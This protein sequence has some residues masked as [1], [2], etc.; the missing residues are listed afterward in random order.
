MDEPH[1]PN[2][3]F[4]ETVVPKSAA[5]E[6]AATGDILPLNIQGYEILNQLGGGAF[7]VVY[8]AKQLGTNRIV[9]IKHIR[10]EL[11]SSEK[12]RQ[13]FIREASIATQMKH[14]N[15]VECLGF[16]FAQDSPY[17]VMEYIET[18]DI[19]SIAMKHDPKRRLRLAVKIAVEVLDALQYAHSRGIV[20]RDVK[21]A[22]ILAQRR[23]QRLH[24]KVSDFGLAKLF[25][26]AG[27]SG[28]T[29]SDEVC[30]TLAY[31][32]PEQLSN[33]RGAGPECDVYSVV[34]CLFR[35]ITGQF[36]F[37][38]GTVAEIVHRKLN[39]NPKL[40]SKLNSEV[41]TDLAEIIDRGLS[42]FRERSF[43]SADRL[44]K[45]LIAVPEMKKQ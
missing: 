8:K 38:E 14:P 41:S 9:A 31:M 1:M 26:T 43:E 25:Q 45:A 29:Q 15:I 30:G 34:V 24:V 13:L 12:A 35:L 44:I 39:E 28:I 23:K 5:F 36:P 22:N 27:Y 20:H 7:G 33:S 11:H 32:A 3:P 18:E 6:A 17:L 10:P 19:E 4:I 40:V 2:D 37:E 42:R 21:I 16:G